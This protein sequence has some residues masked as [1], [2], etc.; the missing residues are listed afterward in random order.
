MIEAEG[1]REVIEVSKVIDRLRGRGIN[2]GISDVEINI[3]AKTLVDKGIIKITKPEWEQAMNDLLCVQAGS[4]LIKQTIK[5]TL[6]LMHAH[7]LDLEKK[8]EGK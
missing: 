8:L 2:I 7:I 5:R 3:I 4:E 6:A 1:T